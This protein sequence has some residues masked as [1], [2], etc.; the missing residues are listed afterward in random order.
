MGCALRDAVRLQEARE[1]FERTLQIKPY[2]IPAMNNLATIYTNLD[3]KYEA[4]FLLQEVLSLDPSQLP[5]RSN[6]AMMFYQMNRYNDALSEY[7]K[8]VEITPNSKEAIF[9]QR[10]IILIMNLKQRRVDNR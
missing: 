3:R 9:A 4:L 5:A 6:L 7:Y 8:I 2:D 10:M 1:E